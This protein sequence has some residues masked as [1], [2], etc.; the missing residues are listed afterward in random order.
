M[1]CSVP[2]QEARPDGLESWCRLW[3]H[4]EVKSL[5]WRTPCLAIER[6]LAA[7]AATAGAARATTRAI[8][9]TRPAAARGRDRG[10]I[11][12]DRRADEPST[13]DSSMAHLPRVTSR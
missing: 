7:P 13:F 4:P 10:F 3:V 2:L 9:V 1:A 5:I 12:G 8:A 11:T 6:S